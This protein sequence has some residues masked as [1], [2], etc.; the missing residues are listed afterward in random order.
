MP[1]LVAI[2]TP[3]IV[4]DAYLRLDLDRHVRGWQK[5]AYLRHGRR[6]R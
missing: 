5:W 3:R 6:T 1:I 4:R 2:M